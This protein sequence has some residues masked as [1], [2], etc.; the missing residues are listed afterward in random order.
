MRVSVVCLLLVA[1]AV[2][3]C[4]P[5]LTVAGGPSVPQEQMRE[6]RK[7]GQQIAVALSAKRERPGFDY[8][9]EL[10]HSRFAIQRGYAQRLLDVNAAEGPLTMNGAMA[11]VLYGS[12]P[13]PLALH[14]GIGVGGYDAKIPGRPNPY[15]VVAGLGAVAG[16]TIGAGR[17]RGLVELQQQ[18]VLSDYGNS[19]FVFSTFVPVRLGIVIQ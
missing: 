16:A 8:R 2:A 15:G 3:A 18:A 9:I 17:V 4:A 13:G 10:T 12:T 14:V 7:V 5:A 19:D 11:Y 6:R 1:L